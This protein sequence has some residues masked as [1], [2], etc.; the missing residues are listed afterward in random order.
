[1][2]GQEKLKQAHAGIQEKNE[3]MMS[4]EKFIEESKERMREEATMKKAKLLEDQDWM[5]V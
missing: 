1:M 3:P 2:T 4:R 5:I